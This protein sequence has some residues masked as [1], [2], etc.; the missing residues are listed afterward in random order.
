M[1]AAGEAEGTQPLREEVRPE[2]PLRG[3]VRPEVGAGDCCRDWGACALLPVRALDDICVLGTL[4]I[5]MPVSFRLIN[6]V[7]GAAHKYHARER[8]PEARTHKR[9]LRWE[10]ATARDPGK[11]GGLP[12]SQRVS[13]SDNGHVHVHVAHAHGIHGHMRLC[14]TLFW[15]RIR[16]P[17]S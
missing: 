2:V 12:A 3:E 8:K 5:C 15:E 14:R 13:L 10:H 17:M 9:R 11:S 16:I 4:P 6:S 1:G 7:H